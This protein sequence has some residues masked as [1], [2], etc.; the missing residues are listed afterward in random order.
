MVSRAIEAFKKSP[1]E[2]SPCNTI[3]SQSEHTRYKD[4]SHNNQMKNPP[5]TLI[6]LG[7]FMQWAPPN[8]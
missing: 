3:V 8:K 6:D 5:P 7:Q 4:A 1:A 2:E